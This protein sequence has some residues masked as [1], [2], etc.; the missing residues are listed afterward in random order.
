MKR[1]RSFS[2]DCPREAAPHGLNTV[3]RPFLNI[4][5]AYGDKRFWYNPDTDRIIRADGLDTYH[6]HMVLKSPSDFGIDPD[7]EALRRYTGKPDEA[8]RIKNYLTDDYEIPTLAMQNGWV[9]VIYSPAHRSFEIEAQSDQLARATL[10][11]FLALYGV[12]NAFVDVRVENPDSF[13]LEDDDALDDYVTK[14]HKPRRPFFERYTNDNTYLLQYLRDAGFDPYACWGLCCEWIENNDLLEFMSDA[15]GEDINSAD[16]LQEYEPDAFYKLSEA[17]QKACGEWCVEYLMQHDPA[18]APS[19]A[20]FDVRNKK[21]LDRETWLV[22]FSDRAHD[23]ARNGFTIGM[24]QMDQLGLTTW[25][26]DA[27]KKYGGYNFAFLADSRDAI[28]AAYKHKYGSDAVLFQN[29]G[30]H[31]HHWGDEEDQVIFWGRDVNPA[32]IV[33]LSRDGDVWTVNSI[34]GRRDPFQGKYQECVDWVMK[35]HRQY[36]SVIAGRRR[37]PE[38]TVQESVVLTESAATATPVV[39]ENWLDTVERYLAESRD[40]Q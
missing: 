32:D 24:D 6:N 37:Q 17:D 10:D 25:F 31:V 22:H 28:Y 13:H 5:E 30:V 3:M 2:T 11:H 36:Q 8:E 29:S 12:T 16:E 4:V 15:I 14:G 26:K 39:Q 7:H 23:I 35:N 40:D 38:R 9:R 19:T 34:D 27:A 1:S 20:H 21:L 33:L 18:E